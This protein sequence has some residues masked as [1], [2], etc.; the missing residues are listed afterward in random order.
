MKEKQVFRFNRYS[1]IKFITVHAMKQFPPTKPECD[2][3]NSLLN[4]SLKKHNTLN[5]FMDIKKETPNMKHENN[6]K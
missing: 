1:L 4:H 6:K 3:P 5:N 2:T